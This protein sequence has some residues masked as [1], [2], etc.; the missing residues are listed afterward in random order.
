MEFFHAETYE[1]AR[2][3][4]QRL[5]DNSEGPTKIYKIVKSAYE[6]YD[7]VAVE[8]DLYADMVST[9]WVDGLPTIRQF[10]KARLG[11]HVE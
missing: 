1:D 6:G 3:E 9:H 8:S 2:R 5:K 4:V 11:D 7:I 10:E